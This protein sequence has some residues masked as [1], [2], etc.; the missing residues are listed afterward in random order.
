MA[1]EL[2]MRNNR[3]GRSGLQVSEV[4]LGCMSL[5]RAGATAERIVGRALDLGVSF[6]DTADLYGHGANEELLARALGAR[7]R[8]VVI[9]TKV[10]NRWRADGSGWHW[11]PSP[12]YVRTAV[13]ASLKRLASDYI[14]LYQLHGGTI[15]DPIDELIATFDDLV[16]AGKI[17][18]WGI[19]SIRPNVIRRYASGSAI[20]SVMMQYSLLDRRPEEEALELLRARGIAVIA[21]GPVAKGLLAGRPARAV[22]DHDEEQVAGL[23]AIVK[24]ASAG[25]GRAPAQTALRFALSAPAVATVIP[26]ASTLAQLEQ[27]VATIATPPL[28]PAELDALR[29]AAPAGRYHLH[30]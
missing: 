29:A 2:A 22:P 10:G 20:A 23:Q 24:Q 6:F 4:G 8:D 18:T 25:A 1:Y 16:Q 28:D 27:N 7:R 26:G 9:A 13:E 14:D 5:A 11:D 30:R 12:A 19:S 21:R 3:L 17:R 15:E